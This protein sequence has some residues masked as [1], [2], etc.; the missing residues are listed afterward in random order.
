MN[1]KQI[2]KLIDDLKNPNDRKIQVIKA[3]EKHLKKDDL[4][5]QMYLIFRQLS[6]AHANVRNLHLAHKNGD[7]PQWAILDSLESI[8]NVLFEQLNAMFEIF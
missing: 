2:Q 3:L 8:D 6:H 1:K 4:S 5:D 7:V